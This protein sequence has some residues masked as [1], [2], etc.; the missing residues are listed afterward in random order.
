MAYWE[1][2][3]V[4]NSQEEGAPDF[5]AI[6][7]HRDAYHAARRAAE[8]AAQ[9]EERVRVAEIAAQAAESTQSPAA[10]L[11]RAVD[12]TRREAER[13]RIKA[14]AA[15]RRYFDVDLAT[16]VEVKI[17]ELGDW[18]LPLEEMKS[19]VAVLVDD[20]ARSIRESGRSQ[21][22]ITSV[23]HMIRYCRDRLRANAPRRE[24]VDI[25]RA[26]YPVL[27]KVRGLEA[28]QER[29]WRGIKRYTQQLLPFE[30]LIAINQ[31]SMA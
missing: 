17:I 11:R 20:L 6:E 22:T 1:K 31:A 5:P 8:L 19:S 12:E 2:D 29:H 7:E 4:M 23:N 21:S 24:M 3:Y 30:E 27:L 15:D 9:M 28:A 13:L 16:P 14:A 25:A 26:F 18:L 10:A